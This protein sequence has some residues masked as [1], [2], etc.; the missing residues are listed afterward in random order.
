M[1]L[2][3]EF[4]DFY[5][6]IRINSEAAVLKEKREILQKDFENNFPDIINDKFKLDIKKSDL[7]FFDQGSYQK[8]T[9]T[10]IKSKNG[11]VDRDIA[12]ILPLDITKFDDP[13]KIKKYVKEA[14]TINNIRTPIIKEPC[15][16]VEYIKK[17]EEW[18]HVDFPIY[19]LH[20]DD[21]TYLGRGKENSKDYIWEISE[22][23]KLNEHF[24]SNLNTDEGKQLRR[25]IRYLKK[26][27]QEKYS[28]PSSDNQVPPS[29]GLTLMACECFVYKEEDD[30]EYDL[31]SLKITVGNMLELFD[32]TGV[33]DDLSAE[34]TFNLPVEPKTDVFFKMK[35]SDNHQTTFYKR[36]LNLYNDLKSAVDAEHE[37]ES[38]KCVQRQLGEEFIV[39]EKKANVSKNA[40][41]DNN[42]A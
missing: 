25:I 27:K 16:T 2:F 24:K 17:G 31:Q 21:K 29:I 28:N 40:K 39:P 32:V 22:P 37:H 20:T 9:K 35:N 3:K 34:I 14:I 11:A 4:K 5:D 12:V 33:D 18:L 19:A 36:M 13:R 1:K 7:S 42:F 10:T 38:G 41:R 15:V 23:K 6:E 8:D 26:W 30:K